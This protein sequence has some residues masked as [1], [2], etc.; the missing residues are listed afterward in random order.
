LNEKGSLSPE[1]LAARL[2]RD[3][4]ALA[5]EVQAG[6]MSLRAAARK[7]GILKQADPLH[8]LIPLPTIGQLS[9]TEWSLPD[10]LT[11]PQ[12]VEAGKAL[13]RIDGTVMW[14]VGDWWKAGH[15]YGE[16][17]ALVESDDWEGPAWDACRAAGHVAE[18]FASARRRAVLSF[19]HH[20]EVAALPEDEAD[21]LLD[22]CEEELETKGRTPTRAALRERVK[23]V[24]RYLAEGWDSDQLERR[25]LVEQGVT[26]LATYANDD[27]KKP[28]DG[29]L[30]RPPSRPPAARP[31]RPE[32]PRAWLRP[33]SRLPF[34]VSV[35]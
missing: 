16:R 12:W 15:R 18:A 31:A 35:A 27:D 2:A 26:V 4:E 28:L 20:R 22:W 11:E 13:A 24:K 10:K 32:A 25:A 17:K 7:A 29:A 3:H 19:G 21:R 8:E 9:K 30:L 14:W 5:A 34:K 23:E 33:P 1:R 6:R